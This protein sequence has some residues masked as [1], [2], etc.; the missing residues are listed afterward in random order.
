M[1]P[2]SIF[3]RFLLILITPVVTSQLVVSI[4][5]SERY[6]QIVLGIISRQMVGEAIAVTKLLD[7]QCDNRYIDAIKE[8]MKIK[9]EIISNKQLEKTGI[10]KSHKAYRVL[11]S[12][13]VKR[14]YEK[15]YIDTCDESME[16]YVPSNSNNDIYK[17]SFARKNLY[18]KIIP[19]VLGSGVTSALLLIVIALIFLKNQ[20]RPIKKL[21]KAAT[22]FGRGIDTEDYKP[23]GAYEIRV[24]GK[25]FCEMK[26]QVKDLMDRRL[27]VLAGISHDLRTPLTKMK[28]QLS[29]MPKT[30]ETKWLASDVNM[31]IKMTESFT[32]HVAEQNNEA[33]TVRSLL[34]FLTEVSRGHG[35]DNFKVH[36]HGAADLK[37]PIKYISL[38][39]AFGN[40]VA[41]AKRYA[42]NIHIT[43]TQDAD[44]VTIRFVDDGPGVDKNIV[45]DI[46]SPFVRQDSARTHYEGVGVGL[47]LSIA[48]DAITAH[49]GTISIDTTQP[50]GGAFVVTIPIRD[51]AQ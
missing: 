31:M 19:V 35:S 6:T 2:K 20:T 5:F 42:S 27:K 4:I 36:I 7:M 16:I 26:N 21:A 18:M 15:Y 12:A 38:K 25:A 22:E 37:I 23:E 48:K 13:L 41:N 46:F 45:D 11:R 8:S 34:A 32:I 10:S 28:L 49:G 17:I 40:I 3:F 9:I 1:L 44:V 14:G 43:F 30:K 33:F 50:H 47:G 39:R 29:L 24:A 51:D